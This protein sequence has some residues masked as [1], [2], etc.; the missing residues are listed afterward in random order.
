MSPH[1]NPA[2]RAR[3][4]RVLGAVPL[5][6]VALLAASVLASPG[7]SAQGCPPEEFFGDIQG[8]FPNP[9]VPAGNPQ[10][11]TIEVLGK[12][13]F[14]DEQVSID[15]TMSCGTCHFFE[16]GGNDVHGGV[17]N[18]INGAKGSPGVLAQDASGNYVLDSVFPAQRRVTNRNAPTPINA[19]FFTHL[20][21]DGDA[22]P[23]FR[24][25]QGQ[26]IPGFED[27][28]ALESLATFPPVSP[29][30]MGHGSWADIE[31]KMPSL[32]AL[33]LATNIPTDLQG[34]AGQSYSGL[35]TTA[36]GP[37]PFGEPVVSR[38]RFAMAVA[39]YMRTLVSDQA[40]IMGGLNNLT[41]DAQAGFFIFRDSADCAGCHSF[42]QGIE[43]DPLTNEFVE[44]NDFLFTH[45]GKADVLADPDLCPTKVPTL[46]GVA[47]MPHLES[48]GKFDGLVDAMIDHYLPTGIAAGGFEQ[49]D[50][51]TLTPTELRNVLDFFD[52]L[53]DPRVANLQGPFT[54]PTL[55]SE[56]VP[57]GSNLLG[58]GS[59]GAGG[60][61]PAIFANAPARIGN[62]DFKLGV[63]NAEG[64][65]IAL[66]Y[67]SSVV[68]PT[69]VG[70]V[71]WEIGTGASLIKTVF[72]SGTTGVA[73]EGYG[74][75]KLPI[76]QIPA[77]IGTVSYYQVH[78]ADTSLP[79][80][81]RATSQAARIE[82]F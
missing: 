66:L 57:F 23:E 5:S 53:V 67:R 80:G 79:P 73:G 20:F 68:G 25:E 42:N 27:F 69:D 46:L 58:T 47:L 4:A 10:D 48:H 21:W 82:I 40:P 43:I 22:E 31:A 11:A 13:L 26:V 54:R 18:P 30:E 59:T 24:D 35:F 65:A 6:A 29:V 61:T 63:G 8:V 44:P 78:V 50:G 12:A 34:I 32:R 71:H 7:A 1:P 33:D 76:P 72:L 15:R 74:T 60:L 70:C 3:S 17:L 75:F 55:R 37:P 52:A 45:G 39:Q 64:G 28:A 51:S 2:S 56:V 81:C 14:W 62:A 16:A 49:G 77:L 19:A 41:P 36:F 38:K 9:A